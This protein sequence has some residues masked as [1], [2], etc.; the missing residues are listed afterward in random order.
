[1]KITTRPIYFLGITI[2]TFLLSCQE[3][4]DDPKQGPIVNWEKLENIPEGIFNGKAFN[5]T[6]HAVA[7]TNFYYNL[8]LT[9]P[10]SS[11]GFMDFTTQIGRYKI[12]IAE[13]IFVSRNET[14]IF[15]LPAKE[16]YT[17]STSIKLK[18]IDKDFSAFS[19]IPSWQGE[20]FGLTKSGNA[21]FSYKTIDKNGLISNN[22][23]FL[24]FRSEIENE[25][26][27]VKDTLIIKN[28][29]FNF[30]TDCFKIETV[31]EFFLA[32]IGNSVFMFSQKGDFRNISTR[33]VENFH[34]FLKENEIFVIGTEAGT[35]NIFILKGNINGTNWSEVGVF[36]PNPAI[37]NMKL[38]NIQNQIIGF[39]KNEIFTIT[40][41]PNNLGIKK[42]QNEG[43]DGGIIS[44]ISLFK[45]KVL[46]TVICEAGLPT[47]CGIYSKSIDDFFK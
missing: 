18:E 17:I 41:N 29:F 24:L 32:H 7:P 13:N 3:K 31:S 5:D 43:I 37:S 45:N 33:V 23:S 20:A 4:I 27:I 36:N 47:S 14:E 16:L 44:S 28:E 1:M 38:T 10:V 19:D 22:P 6:F 30:P 35:K 39:S 21:L 46:V 26:V 2:L 11:Q 34:A 42:L 40:I 15:L 9:G 8:N 25:Q 12:P